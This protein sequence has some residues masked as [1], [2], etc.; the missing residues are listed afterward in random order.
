MANLTTVCFLMTSATVRSLK[1]V[2]EGVEACERS[3]LS[4]GTRVGQEVVEHQSG[5]RLLHQLAVRRVED[6]E[7]KVVQTEALV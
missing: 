7:A 2:P 4:V 6:Q 5:Q 1:V 3:R